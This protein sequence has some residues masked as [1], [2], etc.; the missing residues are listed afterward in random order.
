MIPATPTV[1]SRDIPL[2]TPE[3]QDT[4][5]QAIKSS[6]VKSSI[7]SLIPQ[8]ADSY[9]PRRVALGLPEALTGIYHES[10]QQLSYPEL[11][12]K[13]EEVF[14]TIKVTEEQVQTK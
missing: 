12:N 1:Q 14:S 5:Y 4:L 6:G 11:A 13:C 8:Y 3:E 7:L 2:P 9:I 10:A